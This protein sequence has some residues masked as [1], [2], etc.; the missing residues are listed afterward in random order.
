MRHTIIH[1]D[2][3]DVLRDLDAKLA[4]MSE[5]E[6]QR[7]AARPRS[8]RNLLDL[9]EAEQLAAR[10]SNELSRRRTRAQQARDKAERTAEHDQRLGQVER[11]ADDVMQANL[12]RRRVRA[13]Y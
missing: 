10:A 13:V 6:L 3:V 5:V 1:R 8:D 11:G 2:L 12:A 4:D 7:L 9:S